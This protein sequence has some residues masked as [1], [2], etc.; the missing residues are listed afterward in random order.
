MTVTEPINDCNNFPNCKRSSAF[1]MPKFSYFRHI[2]SKN[3]FHLL[4]K[5][6]GYGYVCLLVKSDLIT[7]FL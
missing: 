4:I 6:I 3:V 1:K 2:W 5:M 7:V